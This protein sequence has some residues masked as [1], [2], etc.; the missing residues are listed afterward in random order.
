KKVPFRIVHEASKERYLTGSDLDTESFQIIDDHF[1]I[2]EE[3]GPYLIQTDK[4]GKVTAFFETEIDGKKVRSPDNYGV[5][6]PGGPGE[7][8][9]NVNL[10]RSKG[11]EGMAASKDGKFLYPLLEGPVWDEK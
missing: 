3:F 11:Y 10:K 9:K 4:T 2:G 5:S 7:T 8:Y 1:W 6:S